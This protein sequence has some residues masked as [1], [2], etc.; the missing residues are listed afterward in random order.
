MF[1]IFINLLSLIKSYHHQ[2]K[3]NHLQEIEKGKESLGTTKEGI[4]PKYSIEANRTGIRMADLLGD[5]HLFEENLD[6]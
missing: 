1:S 4:G 3:I 6:H 2:I 5:L